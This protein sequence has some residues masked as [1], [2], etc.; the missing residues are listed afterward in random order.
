MSV[1]VNV[2]VQSIRSQ[3]PF[4]RGGCIFVGAEID[5]TVDVSDAKRYFVVKAAGRQLGN[6]QVQLGQWWTVTGQLKAFTRTINGFLIKEQQIDAE[7]IALTKVSG[8]KIVSFIADSDE[9]EGIGWVKA[10]RMWD[11]FGDELYTLLDSADVSRLSAVLSPEMAKVAAAAWT[12][13][14]NNRVLQWLQCSGID[15]HTGK[16][17]IDYF[18]TKTEEKLAEDPYRLLSFSAD[19]KNV[20]AFARTRFR[21]KEDDPRRLQAAV[22]QALYRLFDA[23][24]TVATIPMLLKRVEGVLGGSMHRSLVV[25]ALGAG[26]TNGSYVIGK[27]GRVHLLSAELMERTVAQAVAL[28]LPAVPLLSRGQTNDVIQKYEQDNGFDI[29]IEQRRAVWLA[30]ENSMAVIVGTAGAGKTTVLDVILNAYE[31]A[32]VSVRLLALHGRAVKQMAEVTRMPASTLANFFSSADSLDFDGPAVVVVNEASV[33]DI[34]TMYRLCEL[35]PAHVRILMVGDTSQPMPVGPGLVLHALVKIPE[36]PVVELNQFKHYGGAIASAAR[37]IRAGR[38]PLL[39]QDSSSA[40]SFVQTRVADIPAVVVAL[41]EADSQ[42]TQILSA[43][44]GNADGVQSLNEVCQTRFTKQNSAL[45]LRN[46][47]F[48]TDMWSG[49]NV[50]DPLLC[51]KNLWRWG[52]QNGS[53]GTLVEIETTPRLVKKPEGAEL[54][55]AI[56]WV[57]WDDGERRPITEEMLPDLELSYALDINRA[58][59][60]KWERVIV[61]L[62]GNRALDRTLVYA[63]I[64]RAQVQV[65]FVGDEAAVKAAV[66]VQPKGDLRSVGLSQFLVQE[67]AKSVTAA[68]LRA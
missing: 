59:G 15:F 30:V 49:F 44:K 13:Q 12:Q 27:N 55:H 37:D 46:A 25:A 1:S 50:G 31:I 65:I 54:G 42:N 33:V 14:A 26:H 18:D 6:A 16:R 8:E 5:D 66:E 35:L 56:A 9:F 32:G 36:I 43:R 51:T 57:E 63:A 29:D 19:W 4:G 20:D 64:T 22:E 60:S 58:Q 10:K 45:L 3:N 47:E 38:W 48:N 7:D 40:I 11:T 17:L 2:R 28:R 34:V 24:N 53:L 68:R 67:I 21:V 52:V 62:T 41:Y 61:V 23:G 39:P